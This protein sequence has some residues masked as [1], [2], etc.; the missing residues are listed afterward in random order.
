MWIPTL[1]TL[2]LRKVASCLHEQSQVNTLIELRHDLREE[3]RTV[4]IAKTVLSN[5]VIKL[6]SS[7]KSKRAQLRKK[8]QLRLRDPRVR[9]NIPSVVDLTSSPKPVIDLTMSSDSDVELT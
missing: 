2:A 4:L 1:K 5:A 3:V 6:A 7:V 8:H 9:R